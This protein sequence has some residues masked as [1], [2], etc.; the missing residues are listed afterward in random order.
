[1][2]R[3]G[4]QSNVL[5]VDPRAIASGDY[6]S[7]TG[8]AD[9]V[10]QL[11]FH[12]SEGWTLNVHTN[13]HNPKSWLI[14]LICGIASQ[15][16]PPATLTLHSG[17]VPLYLG[18]GPQ[19][20]RFVARL[21]CAMYSRIICVNP[22]IA[23]SISRLGVP[24]TTLEIAP[25]FLPFEAPDVAV[26][27]TIDT[28]IR[29]H[30]P[31]LSTAMFFRREYGFELLLD[32]VKELKPVH[33]DLGCVV[34]GDGEHRDSAERAVERA[35]LSDSVLLTGDLEHEMCLSL[36][37][38]S[39]V[40]VRPT[41]MDGD[42][43][44]VREA[45]ALGVP[46]VASNVGTRPEGT[47][48]FEV[49]NRGQLVE[50]IEDVLRHSPPRKGGVARS[51]GVVSSERMLDFADLTTRSAPSARPPLLCEEGNVFGKNPCLKD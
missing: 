16:G 41:F 14:A 2:K 40:F 46:V 21:A 37:A 48:L 9:F 50:G 15:W 4:L 8:A 22:E 20:R 7:I 26:P 25:A 33:R 31:V 42:A 38:T 13:G 36:I 5:N 30:S 47:T 6:I 43:I 29:Q 28:W 17:G 45:L 39:D 34:M 24:D 3:E 44:S 18:G 1:M 27:E 19:R 35:G 11:F 49:G 10:R 51:A 32:A 23:L 12:V